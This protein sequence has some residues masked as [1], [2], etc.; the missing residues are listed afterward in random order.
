MRIHRGDTVNSL[1]LARAS[2]AFDAACEA[3]ILAGLL[4]VATILSHT[5]RPPPHAAH[6]PVPG[7]HPE[8]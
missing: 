5:K 6:T 3:S 7:P 2:L 8:Q 4:T 1:V